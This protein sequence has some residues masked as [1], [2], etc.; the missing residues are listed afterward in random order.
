MMK[1]GPS[2]SPGRGRLQTTVRCVGFMPGVVSGTG[3]GAEVI[4]SG[5]DREGERSRTTVYVSKHP[6]WHRNRGLVFGCGMSLGDGLLAAQVV[7]GIEVA[8][9]R[10]RRSRGTWEPVLRYAGGPKGGRAG[11]GSTPSGGTVRG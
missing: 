2:Q 5:V 3:K 1:V 11:R 10:F 6:R 4:A 9:A 8:R 7:P